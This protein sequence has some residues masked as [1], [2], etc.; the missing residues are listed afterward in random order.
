MTVMELMQIL[1]RVPKDAR[2]AVVEG[3]DCQNKHN[4]V[5]PYF[6]VDGELVIQFWN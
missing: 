5:S 3:D 4:V 2:I 6:S 1:E